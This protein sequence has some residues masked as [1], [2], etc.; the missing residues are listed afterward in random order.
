MKLS[1]PYRV[2]TDPLATRPDRRWL[3]AILS[4]SEE[5]C[6]WGSDWPH[7]PEAGAHRGCDLVTLYRD[8]SYDKLVDDF[9]AALP[10]PGLADQILRDNPARLYGF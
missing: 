6:V 8:L 1:A 9:I 7:P 3:D 2:S 10:S 4:C 5:R